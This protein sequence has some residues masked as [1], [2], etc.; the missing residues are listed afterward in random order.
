VDDE[1]DAADLGR[2][3][4]ACPLLVLWGD[5]GIAS[6]AQDP[7]AAWRPWADDL[8]GQGIRAGHFLPEEAP[9]ETLAALD[10]FL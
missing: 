9:T 6:Q 3:R 2:R 7:L 10:A 5:R 1:L 4:I 8:R